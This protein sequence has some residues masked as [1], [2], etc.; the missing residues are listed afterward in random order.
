MKNFCNFW[1]VITENRLDNSIQSKHSSNV[2]ICQCVLIL[3]HA[4]IANEITYFYQLKVLHDTYCLGLKQI[5]GNF[6]IVAEI[7]KSIQTDLAQF[8]HSIFIYN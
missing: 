1:N 2:R 4:K 3:H 5:I 6:S 8:P 7:L